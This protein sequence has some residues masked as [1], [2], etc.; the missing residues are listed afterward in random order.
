MNYPASRITAHSADDLD[1]FA[2]SF[3]CQSINYDGDVSRNNSLQAASAA[4]GLAAYTRRAGGTVDEALIDLAVDILHLADAL[5]LDSEEVHGIA[6]RRYS[7]ELRG[8]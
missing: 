4:A 7:E 1:R 8:E 3:A 6:M 5:G 2:Q